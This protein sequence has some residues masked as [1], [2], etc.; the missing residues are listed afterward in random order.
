MLSLYILLRIPTRHL[1]GN[2]VLC[3]GWRPVMDVCLSA[4]DP[5]DWELHLPQAT[6]RLDP[7][8]LVS[9]FL[10]SVL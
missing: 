4:S 5:G 7:T 1:P 9:D 8:N 6:L 10:A 2:C 3:P